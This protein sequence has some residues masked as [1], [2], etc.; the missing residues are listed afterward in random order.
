MIYD[1]FINYYKQVLRKVSWRD[2]FSLHF[3]RCTTTNYNAGTYNICVIFVHGLPVIVIP[4]LLQSFFSNFTVNSPDVGTTESVMSNST[5]MQ[6]FLTSGP[7]K[8]CSGCW[9]KGTKLVLLHPFTESMRSPTCTLPVL[10][11]I[12]TIQ[13]ICMKITR[14]FI[15]KMK[16]TC[17]WVLPVRYNKRRVPSYSIE[18]PFRTDHFRQP[19]KSIQCNLLVPRYLRINRY[20]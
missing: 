17:Q 13:S 16:A 14:K 19:P 9:N 8:S 4:R 12:T 7:K 6:A 20:Y 10:S 15:F 5:L 11:T 1:I 3:T 2:L 18:C